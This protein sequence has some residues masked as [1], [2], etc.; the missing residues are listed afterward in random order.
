LLVKDEKEGM[1][2]VEK[3]KAR[4]GKIAGLNGWSEALATKAL[5]SLVGKR[6]V[7]IDRRG[8]EAV[9]GCA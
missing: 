6:V 4:L 3:L 5:Y 9:F 7:R 8:K 1:I 2:S